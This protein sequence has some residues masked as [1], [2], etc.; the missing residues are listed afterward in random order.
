MSY[1]QYK[2]ERRPLP[3]WDCDGRGCT[4]IAPVTITYYWTRRDGRGGHR[5]LNFCDGHADRW[6]YK[7]TRQLSFPGL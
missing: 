6:L 2:V 4:R 7:H 1:S 3:L 5:S